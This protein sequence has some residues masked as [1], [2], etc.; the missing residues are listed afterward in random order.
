ML[1]KNKAE[2]DLQ[3][4]HEEEKMKKD[5]EIEEKIKAQKEVCFIRKSN[6]LASQRRRLKNYKYY[7]YSQGCLERIQRFIPKTRI[8][9]LASKVKKKKK[10]GMGMGMGK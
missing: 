10:K 8:N 6:V 2:L 7:C 1:E 9:F 3:W 4:S 5:Q